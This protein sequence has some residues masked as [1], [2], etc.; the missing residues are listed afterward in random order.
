MVHFML[1]LD[2]EFPRKW[3]FPPEPEMGSPMVWNYFPRG[4]EKIAE[5]EQSVELG[6]NKATQVQILALPT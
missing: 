5:G 4:K 1:P 6:A 3:M 2:G